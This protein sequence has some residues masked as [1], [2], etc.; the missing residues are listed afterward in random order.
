M[1]ED[2]KTPEEQLSDVEIGNIPKKVFRVIIINL[3]QELGKR[4]DAQN[5]KLQDILNKIR[6]Y[7]QPELKNKITEMRN[8]LE[9]INIRINEVEEQISELENSV[10]EITATKKKEKE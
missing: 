1:K 9:A 4:I 6:K 2:D 7:E 5:K 3:V 8:T 10:V